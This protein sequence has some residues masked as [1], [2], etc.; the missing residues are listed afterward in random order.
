M[1]IG[2][3]N[4]NMTT[5]NQGVPQ[6]SVLGPLLYSIYVNELPQTVKDKE[7]CQQCQNKT[8]NTQYL[9]DENCPQCGITTCFADDS[10]LVISRKTRPENQECITKK[11]TTMTNFLNANKLTV[12][13]PKTVLVESMT[14]Q[15]RPRIKGE[16]PSLKVRKPNGEMKTILPAKHARLL[17]GYI[18]ENSNWEAHLEGAEKAL[19]PDIR[20]KIGAIKHLGV[21][22]PRTTKLRLANGFIISKL[23]YLLPVWGGVPDKYLNRIQVLMNKMA[24]HVNSSGRMSTTKGLMKSCNWLNIRNLIKLQSLTMMWKVV[25]LQAP[26]SISQK[27]TISDEMELSTSRARLQST[28]HSFRW[29]TVKDWNQLPIETREIQS[30]PRFKK[31]VKNWLSSQEEGANHELI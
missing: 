21:N 3:K 18:Q 26:R 9:F 10:T 29:R 15:K 11:L 14:H 20:K 22:I 2:T 4:S 25:W 23:L 6:G 17:G 12:N 27:I 8:N 1:S 7:N 28:Q 24:R 30:L 31:S 13:L 5:L 16:Q 19:L